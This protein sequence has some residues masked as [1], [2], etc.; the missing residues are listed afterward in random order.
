MKCCQKF[1]TKTSISAIFDHLS[2]HFQWNSWNVWL[3]IITKFLTIFA[4]TFGRQFC[5]N[6]GRKFHTI[7]PLSPRMIV[8][9][10]QEWVM[11]EKT[12][13]VLTVSI[14][15]ILLAYFS[16]H[17]W[18]KIYWEFFCNFWMK[19]PYKKHLSSLHTKFMIIIIIIKYILPLSLYLS[20]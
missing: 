2:R 15:N 13:R 14:K 7:S 18:K 19:R 1:W 8:W 6:F 16:L 17:L 20:L 9:T 3:K 12:T 4:Y 5:L 11:T 10:N